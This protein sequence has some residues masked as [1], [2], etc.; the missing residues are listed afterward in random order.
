MIKDYELFIE[1]NFDNKYL[2]IKTSN[3][4]ITLEKIIQES[5]KKFNIDNILEKFLILK[6]ND[7][8]GNINII[9]NEKDILNNSEEISSNKYISKINLDIYPY[10]SNDQII[11]KKN[12]ESK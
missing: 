5:C 9:K 4:I 11:R 10:K 8:N 2:F 6:Y 12:Y 3:G 1:V 7:K